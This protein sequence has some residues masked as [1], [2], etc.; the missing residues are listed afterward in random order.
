[1]TQAKSPPGPLRVALLAGALGQ[2]G[3]E[4]QLVYCARALV[5]AGAEVRLF[6]LTREEAC[7]GPLRRLGLQPIW[8]GPFESPFLRLIA[9]GKQLRPFRPHVVQSFHGFT[10]LY[11]GLLG[12]WLGA[13]SL[14]GLRT[15]LP[16]FQQA[17]GV[18][19]P[20]L[21]RAPA[22]LV[23]NS[24]ALRQEIVDRGYLPLRRTFL[25]PNVV[26]LAE[27]DRLARPTERPVHAD[28]GCC[29]AIFVGRLVPEKRGD[30]FL[31]ALAAACHRG[32]SVT[33][34]V[35]GDGPER[36]S[37]EA[38]GRTLGLSPGQV[39]FLGA[40][41]DIPALLAQA[42]MLVSCSDHEGMPN[43][44]LEAMAARL[45]IIATPAGDLG[46]VVV[47]GV[48]GFVVPFDDVERMGE[49]IAGLAASPDLRQRLGASGRQLVQQVYSVHGLGG[50]LL[51]IYRQTA[52]GLRRLQAGAVLEWLPDAPA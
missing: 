29:L 35:V 13:I 1:M 3:A 51:S 6:S 10:N 33:G 26:D 18:W 7:E 16:H 38:L 49:R 39:T 20:W 5:A 47:D 8:A 14:G 24:H 36:R 50:R 45:P 17:N 15:T 32:A 28:S 4:K 30:R 2:G 9:L 44:V 34:L 42:D 41:A 22:G 37:L 21:L 11:V 40:R 12:R 31:R 25:L 43:V 48:N 27:F 19:T 46:M 23:V 52:R